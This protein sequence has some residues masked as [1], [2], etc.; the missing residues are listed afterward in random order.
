MKSTF[1]SK[2][3]GVAL[4]PLYGYILISLYVL[5]SSGFRFDVFEPISVIAL[6]AGMLLSA[7]CYSFRGKLF[8]LLGLFILF[9]IGG[10]GIYAGLIVTPMNWM[11]LIAS[12]FVIAFGVAFYEMVEHHRVVWLENK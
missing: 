4:I 6:I 11:E 8:H 9:M 3:F 12:A 7:I 10:F 2:I 5:V 1:N